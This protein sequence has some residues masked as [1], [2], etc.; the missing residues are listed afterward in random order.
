MLKTFECRSCGS[1]IRFDSQKEHWFHV[2][3]ADG[4]LCGQPKPTTKRN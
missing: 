1:P 4:E 2:F 3:L